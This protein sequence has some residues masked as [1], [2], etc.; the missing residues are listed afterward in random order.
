VER[1]SASKT[2]CMVFV[3]CAATAIASPAQTFTTLVNFNGANGASPYASLTQGSDGDF[4]GTTAAGGANGNCN[5]SGGCGTIFKVTP[6]GTL[7]TLYS[8][9]TQAGCTDGVSPQAGL[10]RATDGNFYGTTY[11][12]GATGQGQPYVSTLNAPTG[13]VV[14]NAAIEAAGAGGRVSTYATDDTDLVID[15]NGYFAPPGQKGLSLYPATPC[16]VLDTGPFSGTLYPPVDVVGSPCGVPSQPQAYVFNATVVP[17]NVLGY[18]TLWPD[19]GTRPDVSTLNAYDGAVTSN[20]AIVPAGNQGK[21]DAF[22][23]Y[24]LTSLI[25]DI[26]SYFAP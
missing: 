15:I 11:S 6:G 16:R 17:V 3:F 7:T 26:S 14:A 19:G 10:V 9:C 22:A 20:M 21:V 1:F 25:L 4:Y 23:A 2:A 13:T 8:F 24:G 5:I 12:G 18:L